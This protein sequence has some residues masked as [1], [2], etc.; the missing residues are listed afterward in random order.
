MHEQ[1]Q[2]E[3]ALY[4]KGFQR[5]KRIFDTVLIPLA[6]FSQRIQ[7]KRSPLLLERL[8]SAREAIFVFKRFLFSVHEGSIL[9]PIIRAFHF[10]RMQFGGIF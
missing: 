1:K 5:F 9:S 2:V 8:S 6:V 7:Y 3:K 10:T 4:I